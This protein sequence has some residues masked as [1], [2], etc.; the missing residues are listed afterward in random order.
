MYWLCVHGSVYGAPA[1]PAISEDEAYD[2]VVFHKQLKH[3][4]MTYKSP[5]ARRPSKLGT[6]YRK[7][8]TIKAIIRMLDSKI[9]DADAE[10]IVT[11]AI[12]L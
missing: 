8:G 2:E 6:V 4:D 3:Y 12:F 10:T 7:N 9:T 5:P 11:M 1:P